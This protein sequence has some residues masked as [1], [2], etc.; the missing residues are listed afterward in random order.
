VYDR[1]SN[2]TCGGCLFR[3]PT[4]LHVKDACF[5]CEWT[6]SEDASLLRG[7]YKY[8]TGNW[9]AIRMDPELKLADVS[10][11]LLPVNNINIYLYKHAAKNKEVRCAVCSFSES[12]LCVFSVHERS[13]LLNAVYCLIS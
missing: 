1:G 9:D 13:I 3:L 2:V 11:F 10:Y 8:G 7:V 12:D 4:G 6:D 5:D